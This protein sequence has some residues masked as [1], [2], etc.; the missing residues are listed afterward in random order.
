MAHATQHLLHGH[1]PV[2]TQVP[3]V[4]QMSAVT[5][6][7]TVPTSSAVNVPA[8]V[9]SAGLPA[10]AHSVPHAPHVQHVQHVPQPHV[11]PQHVRG[12]V[13]AHVA[14]A[15]AAAGQPPAG[16]MAPPPP[17][18]QAQHVPGH[19][20]AV[21]AAHQAAVLTGASVGVMSHISQVPM[22]H[23]HSHAQQRASMKRT[24]DMVKLSGNSRPTKR[25][26]RLV[27]KF[28]DEEERK[29]EP[30]F[31]GSASR[32][33]EAK[34]ALLRAFDKFSRSKIHNATCL[35]R[36]FLDH[37]DMK[38]ILN[39][40]M[41]GVTPKEM[42]VHKAI[43][44]GLRRK[45]KESA[46]CSTK[47]RIRRSA[48]ADAALSDIGEGS[49]YP[50]V[51]MGKVA[52]ALGMRYATLQTWNQELAK[53]AGGFIEKRKTRSDAT[54]QDIK[55]LVNS[56]YAENTRAA[57]DDVKYLLKREGAGGRVDTHR[58][59]WRE[60][61]FEKLFEK[62]KHDHPS[63]KKVGL[64][65]FKKLCPWWVRAKT[66][67]PSK[68]PKGTPST[69]TVPSLGVNLQQVAAQLASAPVAHAHHHAHAHHLAHQL[70]QPPVPGSAVT[71]AKRAE[72]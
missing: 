61:T 34:M 17:H 16:H 45:L 12:P 14:T 1:A 33:S 49:D 60:V 65:T 54:P 8:G 28:S 56:F 62:F 63:V 10:H 69:A 27:L 3:G 5:A 9:V 55:D 32:R 43:V 4:V 70:P 2:V 57:P 59:H 46:S 72:V 19:V 29:G 68:G 26:R 22:A 25:N 21:N 48:I 42:L 15:A 71:P 64:S 6:V 66:P 38:P 50:K 44:A 35:L 13:P 37:A 51:T 31:G 41:N 53:S 23:P 20:A 39:R 30:P 52:Q 7:S 18:M 58:I 11:A 47:D 40:V 24:T 36:D 67:K